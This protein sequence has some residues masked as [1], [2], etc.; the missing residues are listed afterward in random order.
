MKSTKERISSFRKKISKKA[1]L[2][3]EKPS[4][5]ISQKP[6]SRHITWASKLIEVSEIRNW[7][8]DRHI[9]EINGSQSD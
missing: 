6:P 3:Q 7:R 1:K 4:R 9:D 8:S 5:E 2:V